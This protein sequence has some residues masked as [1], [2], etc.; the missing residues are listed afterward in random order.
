[1]DPAGE[2]S[3]GTEG[4]ARAARAYGDRGYRHVHFEAGPF[5][6]GLYLAAEA[7]GL[8]AQVVYHFAI[9]Y[10]VTAPRLEA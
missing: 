7:L 1:M 4:L 2:A 5:G 10:P 6:R 9:G 8:A 3:V